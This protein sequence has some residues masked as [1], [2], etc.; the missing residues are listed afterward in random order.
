MTVEMFCPRWYYHSTLSEE[1]QDQIKRLF[2]SKVYDDS[3]YT[4]SPWDCNC[5][6]TFQSKTNM[7]LAWNDWLECLRLSIDDALDKLKP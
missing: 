3:I 4:E 6:T 2:E 1:Y 7:E 5:L